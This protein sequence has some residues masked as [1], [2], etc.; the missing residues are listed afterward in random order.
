MKLNFFC[1]LS[2]F[3]IVSFNLEAL[4]QLPRGQ[5]LQINT[6]LKNIMGS[7][8]WLL[9]IKDEDTG[10]IIPYIYDFEYENNSWLAFS[11]GHSYRIIAS[12]LK[13]G[14]HAFLHNFCHLE[15]GVIKGKE[16]SIYITGDLTPL[17]KTSRCHVAQYA[18][19]PI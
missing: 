16:M 9:E 14:P 2:I 4:A 5:V 17:A 1:W 8:T 12:T 11:Q 19:I 15:N 13:F 3:L 7:P 6:K 10:T 18:S